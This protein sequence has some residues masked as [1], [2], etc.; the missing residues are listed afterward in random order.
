MLSH[1]APPGLTK[2]HDNLQTFHRQLQ[3]HCGGS[4]VKSQNTETLTTSQKLAQIVELVNSPEK[5]VG[6]HDNSRSGGS[7]VT[8]LRELITMTMVKWAESDIQDSDLIGRIFSLL[9]RQF[10]EIQEVS[11][12]LKKTYVID[13]RGEGIRA[14]LGSFIHALGS[15]R[16][17]LRVGM[18]K[19]EE[20]LMKASLR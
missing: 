11:A 13:L 16:L 1:K 12:A 19:S 3:E 4:E 6:S 2:L 10:D 9:H 5:R 18:G 20:G 14:E 8:S 15:L 7:H 17:L